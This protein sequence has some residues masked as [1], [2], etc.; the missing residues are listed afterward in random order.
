M[1]LHRSSQ[2][3]AFASTPW[4]TVP[5]LILHLIALWY[6]S[7]GASAAAAN[8]QFAS[9]LR[10]SNYLVYSGDI[11]DDGID[12]LLLRARD[13][14]G[15]VDDEFTIPVWLRWRSSFVVMSSPDGSYSINTTPSLSELSD[16]R[17][18]SGTHRLSFAD[19][20]SDGIEE[21]TA[22]P[23]AD[24]GTS[25]LISLSA[26]TGLPMLRSDGK[27]SVVEAPAS[28]ASR[29]SMIVAAASAPA[30]A[31]VPGATRGSFAVDTVGAARYEIPVWIPPGPRGLQPYL[32]IV[33]N[34]R[35]EEGTMGPGWAVSG[36][37]AVSRC[38]KTFSQDGNPAP[39]ILTSLD[40]YCLDGK[41]LRLTS[42]TYGAASS[43]YQTEL[44]DFSESTATGSAG[45]GP[46]YFVVR[47]KS[48][49]TYEY[50]NS[51]DGG[52]TNTSRITASGTSTPYQWLLN[53]V[54]DRD[55]NKYI[56]TYSTGQSGSV[57]IGVPLQIDYTPTTL[58]A[59]TYR[60]RIAF[61]YVTDNDDGTEIR[62]R[63]GGITLN[64][65]LLTR[66]DI[67]RIDVP[68]NLRSY[69]FSYTAAPTTNR[70]RLTSIQECSDA[71][72]TSCL[73][74]T[75]VTYQNGTAGISATK[76]TIVSN[77]SSVKG[78]HDINGDGRQDLIY[79]V[80]SG[81]APLTTK[82]LYVA[83]ATTTGYGTPISTG[84]T[85]TGAQ[86][87]GYIDAGDLT[88]SGKTDIV[89]GKDGILH[90]YYW[91]G[92]AFVGVSSGVSVSLGYAKLS[93][94][95]GDGLPD[96]ITF[97]SGS[98]SVR[99]NTSS[100][101]TF[102]LAASTSSAWAASSC[103]LPDP[104]KGIAGIAVDTSTKSKLDRVDF[105]GDGRND[106]LV[107][108]TT[109]YDR[110]AYA[111]ISNGTSYQTDCHQFGAGTGGD[112]SAFSLINWN[113]DE[114]TD[115]V[116]HQSRYVR[117]VACNGAEALS[118][119]FTEPFLGVM[120]WNG[121]GRADLLV[122]SGI[123]GGKL[124]VRLST[125]GG[126]GAVSSTTISSPTA[127]AVLDQNGDGL[128]DLAETTSGVSFRL[129]NGANTLP[130]L[131]TSIVDGYGIASS[132][133]YV[134]IVQGSYSKS[135]GA[136][137]PERDIQNPMYVVSQVQASDGTGGTFTKTYSYAGA[138][139]NVQGRGFSGFQSQSVSDSR[140]S[141]P[142][143]KS[144]FK[145][146]FPYTGMPYQK[147]VHQ[148]NGTTL[149]S[150]TTLTPSVLT[151]SSTAGQQR[152]YP[153]IQSS[154]NST[155]EVGG[156]KNGALVRQTSNSFTYDSYGNITSLTTTLTDKD[157][158]APQ[159]PTYNQTWS[160]TVTTTVLPDTTNW[161]LGI[162]TQ[163]TV[164]KSATNVAQ[165]TRTVGFAPDYT[166]CR[167]TQKVV[168]P[169]SA[170]Y[171][172]T[173][174]LG[175]DGFGNVNS[176]TVTGVGMTARS[177]TELWNT[178]GQFPESI[179]NALSQTSTVGYDYNLGVKT[180]A[181]DPNE[182][183]VSWG[184]DVFG[185]V[186]AQTRPDGTSTT[187]G[188]NDCATVAGGCLNGDPASSSTSINKLVV[189]AT[190]KDVAGATLR[191]E[192][193]YLDQL[194]RT[195]IVK[196]KT[197]TGAYSRV[198][199]QYDALGRTYR[200]HAPC[201]VS[202]CSVYWTTSSYDAIDRLTAQ[203]RQV[204]TTDTSSQSTSVSYQG[205]T[206]ITTD[207]L[208]KTATKVADP[209]GWLRQSKDHN[210]YFQSFA[211][212]AYGSLKSVTDSQ[213]N[214][215]FT[216]TYDYGL[217]AFQRQ[218][219]DMDLGTWAYTPNALGEVTGYS[220]AN[221][222][223][224]SMTYDKLSR[225]LT[226]TVS[227]ETA[228]WTWGSSAASHDIG[229]LQ[230]LTSTGGTTET[231]SYDGLGRPSQLQVVSDGTHTYNVTYHSTSGFLDTL[232]YPTSTSS[233]RLKLQ[234][235]YQNGLLQQ[236]SD[237]NAPSTVFWKATAMNPRFQVTSETLGNGVVTNSSFDAVTG[238]LSAMQSGAGGGWSI[239][240]DAYQYDKLGNL[241]QRKDTNLSLTETFAYDN[242]YR[243]DYSQLNGATNLDLSYDALGNITQRCEPTCG[244]TWIYSA[245][246]KH[247]VTQASVGSNSYSYGYD[248]NGNVTTRNG[249]SITWNKFSFPT[250]INGA[251][252]SVA[253]SYDANM[254]RWKQVY[255]QGVVTETTIYIGGLLEKVTTG[256]ATDWRH[257][258]Q[259][260][261][262]RVSIVSRSSSG[263]NTTRYVLEDHEGSVEKL[264]SSSGTTTVGES[265]SAFGARRNPATWSG[266]PTSSDLSTIN[267]ISR[268]GFTG[269][270]AL[271]SLG[272]NHM[273]GRVQDALTGRFLSADPFVTEPGTTQGFNRYSYVYNNPLSYTD[274]TGF[275]SLKKT[276]KK[277][278]RK[279]KKVAKSQVF[280]YIA[281]AACEGA[282]W[283]AG[284]GTC[285]VLVT[286]ALLTAEDQLDDGHRG[287][288]ESVPN[289]ARSPVFAH[290]A[291]DWVGI[292]SAEA[293]DTD[294]TI[295]SLLIRFDPVTSEGTL[296]AL[297][298]QTTVFSANV[299][300]GG[301][302][303][304]TPT[305]RYHA[306]YWET[307]HVSAKY[308]S[309]ADTPWSKSALGW[310]AFGPYQLHI[311]ELEA[312]GIYI[313]GTLGPGWSR[314][315]KI[316]GYA[317][318]ATSHGCVRLCNAD[319]IKLHNLIPNPSGLPILIETGGV[320]P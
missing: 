148:S 278:K 200:Q 202:N 293:A 177:T 299:V 244:S 165:I 169:S 11:N 285:E 32:A 39:V 101:G 25:A 210:G 97:S 106:V 152:Y 8:Y 138:R 222:N 310:N 54:I 254:R 68:K 191:D 305:G 52:S 49:L 229:Q 156:T 309:L 9:A 145:T 18:H 76:T 161:C 24:G 110:N 214:A 185:R 159:S 270:T 250:L 180:S 123:I 277:L 111:L 6:T 125:G 314:T 213:S 178:T 130:D 226:R 209:N 129:H 242:L 14:F 290:G 216:A 294:R 87:R 137:L 196:S 2:N 166:K 301:P 188:Y 27:N 266:A 274:P 71:Q 119:N 179:T 263:A 198:G 91:N 192:S 207:A 184:Y 47:T 117:V 199:I 175:Y 116:D 89:V 150:S 296:S 105:N 31:T 246:K 236:V 36:L 308:G 85:Q 311:K 164:A 3:V 66:L 26:A 186:T 255:T 232:T 297:H 134:S 284:F 115:V 41:R 84:L 160:T 109:R 53:K 4:A 73:S 316:S 133:T 56:V 247:A 230:S 319:I 65:N 235:G 19:S 29:Q 82:T 59:N 5:R 231:Y 40:G 189:I 16:S 286:S 79:E 289:A 108:V 72:L 176:E 237:Y 58:G 303:S 83:F 195:I 44:A 86:Q 307:D 50:G 7:C 74:P 187:Y 94:A 268:D 43:K 227:T 292:G 126:I 288:S 128:D 204:S 75:T 80:T 151:L 295:T 167:I 279:L 300:V 218:I 127:L 273:N 28:N 124:G 238:W 168:E 269:H 206:T 37:S 10:D 258:I 272:L 20:N 147:D 34:S 241:T 113:D 239:Q 17:W 61:N 98:I 291:L 92:S 51:N 225:P 170:T 304:P 190:D 57:G 171:K 149:I 131:V 146:A 63:A 60:Y 96:L 201:D 157:G 12:D 70:S 252:E 139:E 271:G 114:C 282:T 208:G 135:S 219:V 48:G 122:D 154:S 162:P 78:F 248:N 215:L 205:L 302:G 107:F 81:A 251:G 77:S 163:V 55:G 306:S 15:F 259:A 13:Q 224:F 240:N 317:V 267:G 174:D 172:V 46:A 153:Y 211:Y 144:Y 118:L 103:G 132:P 233:Y 287:P 95:N 276:W 281:G 45:N 315:T 253:L 217:G 245:T 33:Y 256:G 64:N 100:S 104:T 62:Y 120:D 23:F 112:F 69:S 265:F 155:Y 88:A 21:M 312:R 99:L 275:F 121:D 183:T 234:Y 93:D 194:G 35:I 260:N 1:R 140:A 136:V 141:A 298:E 203:L 30:I 261:G 22:S 320:E 142:V 280:A 262:E 220:D 143:S 42:G 249:Y 181:T 38:V 67:K 173:T 193:T 283:G 223:S 264:L 221:G 313:H 158:T 197:L 257:S 90:R 318:S 212:D 182:L 228:T 243:L 102:T